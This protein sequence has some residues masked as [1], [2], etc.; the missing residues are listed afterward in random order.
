MNLKAHLELMQKEAI[1][2]YFN[3]QT[4]H[5]LG[6]RQEDEKSK[7]TRTQGRELNS[8][9]PAHEARALTLFRDVS[10]RLFDDHIFRGCSYSNKIQWCVCTVGLKE[11]EEERKWSWPVSKTFSCKFRGT[12]RRTA[13]SQARVEVGTSRMQV[14]R[15][16]V[17]ADLLGES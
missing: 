5:F 10:C 16:T 14:K 6:T 9:P 1:V 13:E 15:A 11:I 12:P 7:D 17:P 4:T 3:A 2:N 8:L